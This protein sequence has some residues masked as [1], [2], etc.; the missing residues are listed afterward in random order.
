MPLDDDLRALATGPNFGALTTL[1]PDGRA[2]THVVWVD[3]DDEALLVNTEIHRPKYR[4]MTADPRVTLTIWDHADPYHFIEARGRVVGTI[5]GQEAR[6]HIDA[7]S[8]RYRG[9]D[10]TGTI[11]S[12]RVIVRI[13]PDEVVRFGH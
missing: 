12:E 1:F 9:E 4:N 11:T 2:Q 3:A 8:R 5:G 10:Y 7:C 13:V 6:D